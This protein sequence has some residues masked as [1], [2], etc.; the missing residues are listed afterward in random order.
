MELPASARENQTTVSRDAVV[1]RDRSNY[2]YVVNEDSTAQRVSWNW[3]RVWV[4]ESP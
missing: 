3:A 4:S 2:V 1:L